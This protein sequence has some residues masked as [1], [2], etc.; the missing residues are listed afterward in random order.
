MYFKMSFTARPFKLTLLIK[1]ILA[2]S[3]AIAEIDSGETL[4]KVITTRQEQGITAMI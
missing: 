2:V 1:S 3:N 4:S